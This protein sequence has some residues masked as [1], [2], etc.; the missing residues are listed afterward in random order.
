MGR[1]LRIEIEVEELEEGKFGSFPRAKIYLDGNMIPTVQT[2]DVRMG[3]GEENNIHITQSWVDGR[4]DPRGVRLKG[5]KFPF[6]HLSEELIHPPPKSPITIDQL[7]K[8]IRDQRTFRPGNRLELF[9]ANDW[10]LL[11]KVLDRTMDTGG[12]ASLSHISAYVGWEPSRLLAAWSAMSEDGLLG[13][14]L[15]VYH[16][17][18][19]HPILCLPMDKGMPNTPFDCPGCE[20]EIEYAEELDFDVEAIM[21]QRVLVGPIS[22]KEPTEG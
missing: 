9:D 1:K 3:S 11:Q 7:E 17:C 22:T 6:V 15:Y 21:D 19:E 18:E 13:L 10:M 8:E 20:E 5:L 12:T 16:H 14:S 2:L 4:E